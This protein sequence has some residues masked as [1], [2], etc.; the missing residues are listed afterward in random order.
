MGRLPLFFFYFFYNTSTNKVWGIYL[1]VC[2][3]QFLCP[4][5]KLHETLY[6]GW[7]LC[8][9]LN[10]DRMFRSIEFS[11][12]YGPLDLEILT[13]SSMHLSSQLLRQGLLDIHESWQ[14][15]RS[16]YEDVHKGRML[17]SIEFSPSYGP[18]D[19][20]ILTLSRVLI[21]CQRPTFSPSTLP[22][23]N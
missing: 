16:T 1:S 23:K 13:L 17:R 5:S 15:V 18:Q 12:S 14:I 20:E 2:P 11:L 9:N 6:S 10:V 21:M 7:Q 22:V 8:V 19:F 3:D 4:S